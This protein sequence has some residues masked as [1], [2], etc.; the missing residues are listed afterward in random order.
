M[1]I[2]HMHMVGGLVGVHVDLSRMKC[3]V[4]LSCTARAQ[5]HVEHCDI[6]VT[7]VGQRRWHF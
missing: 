5:Q 2:L 3:E 6:S 1:H 4:M 7:E